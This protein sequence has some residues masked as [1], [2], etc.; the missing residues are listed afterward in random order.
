MIDGCMAALSS[1]SRRAPRRPMLAALLWP[2]AAAAAAPNVAISL[3]RSRYP[4]D[5]ATAFV[6]SPRPPLHAPLFLTLRR[7]QGGSHCFPG[8]SNSP[9]DAG[10]KCYANWA[11]RLPPIGDNFKKNQTYDYVAVPLSLS[12]A[13]MLPR[14]ATPGNTSACLS[15]YP[16]ACLPGFTPAHFEHFVGA[17]VDFG[18]RPYVEESTGSVVVTLD[19]SLGPATVSADIGGIAGVVSGAAAA[20]V[21]SLVPFSLAKLP[22]TVD[23]VVNI[24]V[25]TKV[26][27]TFVHERVFLRAPPPRAGSAATVWQVDHSRTGLRVDG[28][29]FFGTGWFGAGGEQGVGAGLPPNAY[30][31]FIAGGGGVGAGGGGYFNI[32]DECLRQAALLAEWGK[33]GVN[34]VRVGAPYTS[35]SGP[36]GWS[37]E[38][39]STALR[40]WC[41]PPLHFE[42]C[43]AAHTFDWEFLCNS[44]CSYY[45]SYELARNGPVQALRRGCCTC[46][47]DIP[48]RGPAD[49]GV[50]QCA[51][52]HPGQ[53]GE[54][55]DGR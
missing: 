2:L 42:P 29:R 35:S 27:L 40:E 8:R 19:P 17:A 25:T 31:P 41:A 3:D 14:V 28:K 13:G 9:G 54:L 20:G 32:S 55:D 11:L 37:V 15:Q 46:R 48:D 5:L 18:L 30:L 34:L 16:P 36:N 7:T 22:P 44:P 52:R 10:F 38:S 51:G 53:P 23:E 43:A 49:P 26:G 47:G 1:A 21:G 24:T 33:M 50:G 12:G 45:E 39:H 4:I 6:V